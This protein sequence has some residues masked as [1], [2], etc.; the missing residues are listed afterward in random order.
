MATISMPWG[1]MAYCDSGG[2]G[3]PLL[4]L[5]G[6]G[7]DA[8]D[9][10]RVIERLKCQR[11]CTALDFRGHGRSAVPT[12]PFTLGGLADDVLCLAD[13][14][15]VQNLGIVGHQ[16]GW[17]GSDGS[18]TA[19]IACC[20]TCVVGGMDKP[21]ISGECFR[22]RTVLRFTIQSRYRTDSAESKRN[23]KPL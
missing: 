18:R 3:L 12:N 19:F 8:S 22:C 10:T 14:L 9:W 5:H 11:R 2:S 13:H 16:F 23:A 6:A 4:F 21:F 20:W 17:Y 1:E 7:C 15:S